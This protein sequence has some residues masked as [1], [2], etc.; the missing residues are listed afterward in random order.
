VLQQVLPLERQL[1]EQKQLVQQV[2]LLPVQ[3]VQELELQAQQV[4]LRY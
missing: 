1:G 4:R 2:P 3:Q